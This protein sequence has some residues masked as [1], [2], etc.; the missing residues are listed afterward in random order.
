MTT[1]ELIRGAGADTPS[2]HESLDTYK[3][4]TV[5]RVTEVLCEGPIEGLATGDAR[6]IY[7][8]DVPAMG[9]DFSKNF[10]KFDYTLLT[11]SVDQ[12]GRSDF[13]FV[14]SYAPIAQ[15]VK[16]DFPVV[17]QI[18]NPEVDAVVIL[19]AFDALLTQDGQDL[20]GGKV[21]FMVEMR[22]SSSG[23]SKVSEETIDGKSRSRF[24]RAYLLNLPTAASSGPTY[25]QIRVSR[26]TPDSTE[27]N[28]INKFYL[29]GIT[30]R[31][32]TVM[33]YPYTS[34]VQFK[35]DA[36]QFPNIPTRK[37]L[38][39]LL[40]VQVPSNYNPAT[41]A[42]TGAWDGSFGA[43]QWTDNPAWC[44]Y[45][46]LTSKRYGL[47][48]FLPASQIDRW[49]FYQIARYC[50]QLVPTGRKLENGDAEMEPRFTLNC[51]I[52]T[53]D[54]ALK[55]LSD[56]VTVFRGM[57]YWSGNMFTVTQDSPASP[58]MQ[59][60]PANVADGLFTYQGSSVRNRHTVAVVAWANP[61]N[62]YKTD[63]EYVEDTDGISRYGIRKLELTAF[64][65]TSR[66]QARRVG[67]WALY[68]EL[69]ETETV[70]FSVS[71]D[72]A[73]VRPGDI[74][75]VTD[76][77]R[78][79]TP[80]A[81][82]DES[83]RM[84]GRLKA[85]TVGQL[86]LDSPV[87]LKA[88]ESYTL[89]VLMPDGTLADRTVWLAGRT[90]G[91]AGTGDTLLCS[92][93]PVAPQV[94]SLWMLSRTN[95]KPQLFRVVGVA[96][97]DTLDYEIT[98]V[99]HNPSKYAAIDLA[100]PL[101]SSSS[102]NLDNP[103]I[104][105]PVRNL[106]AV[107]TVVV[108]STGIPRARLDI[109]WQA[110]EKGYA[111]Y[112]VVQYRRQNDNWILVQRGAD[113]WATVKDIEPGVY[114]VQVI[115]VNMAG[116]HSVPATVFTTAVGKTAKPPLP[117][118]VV[119]TGG[120]QQINLA[121]TYPVGEEDIACVEIYAGTSSD[122]TQ[123]QHIVDV[124]FPQAQFANIGLALDTHIYYWIRCRDTSGNVSD[125][126]ATADA[127]TVRDPD[128]ILEHIRAQVSRS[129]LVQDLLRDI[130]LPA[131]TLLDL[132]VRVDWMNDLLRDLK[133]KTDAVIE[134]DPAD[135]RIRMKATK[136][137]DQ[138]AAAVVSEANTRI[139]GQTVV[140]EQIDQVVAANAGNAAAIEAE[141]QA[142]VDA[143]S[144]QAT[145]TEMLGARMTNA[146]AAIS[147]EQTA[148][149]TAD[150]A[151]ATQLSTLGATVSG[152][153]AAITAEQTARANADSALS[154]QIS[155]VSAVANNAQSA[156]TTETNARVTAINSEANTRSNADST[157]QTNINAVSSQVTT[158][159][160]NAAN[161][162]AAV[163]QTLQTNINT[164]SG[165]VDAMYA[166]KIQTLSN[167]RKVVSG[168]G[169]RADATGTEF[170]VVADRF[171]VVAPG[172][173]TLQPMFTIDNSS[174]TPKAVL[175][176]NLIVSGSVAANSIL[177]GEIV[178]D[179]S[180]NNS[181]GRM[182]SSNFS[183]GSAGWQIQGNGSAEF[184]NV[185]VRGT[186]DTGRIVVGTSGAVLV[187][188]SYQ[189]NPLSPV[190]RLVCNPGTFDSA[191]QIVPLSNSTL[192]GPGP[193]VET[194]RRLRGGSVSLYATVTLLVDAYVTLWGRQNGG[195]WQAIITGEGAGDGY[196]PVTLA[197]L[198]N[199]NV[200]AYDYFDFGIS[201]T[202]PSMV[203][204]PNGTL[205]QSP[206]LTVL[207]FNW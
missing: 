156:V 125:G 48:A 37:Y 193:N 169:L 35:I 6:S 55:V 157:L 105:S 2:P 196:N 11:G 134:V 171:Y 5:L 14:E 77:T 91:Q 83:D 62:T 151:L 40:K 160:T 201:S 190:A 17:H 65:C 132:S 76:P 27:A 159:Q 166:V 26:I 195:G 148:R 23:W 16:K 68:T 128:T 139:D 99:A 72:S 155:Q 142:R 24:Q 70:N 202:T 8:N 162:L 110:P 82:G 75:S 43:A 126:W 123:A 79:A 140:A 61:E 118:N 185:T 184:N 49:A 74:I 47:G 88:G 120:V 143:V 20:K 207:G 41:R 107:E 187:D 38:L 81:A 199:V 44:L 21:E 96:C 204:S 50:D 103:A 92:P 164:V 133:T 71:L 104:S 19:I 10:D 60:S 194:S 25:R 85:A 45:D 95:L 13:E 176:G 111:K 127:A 205:I 163:Q 80:T 136:V 117:A 167:G 178:A 113:M 78:L 29:E 32:G 12:R 144:A 89:S 182:R 39:K 175:A 122:Q 4:N 174:G 172:S 94:N 188:R 84:G 170:A 106:L 86:T 108:T 64:G 54:Q 146:E 179:L 154:T 7:F 51:V 177:S 147:D 67:K 135:G 101:E 56:L 42:Y 130:D 53:R 46:L 150:S 200:G 30:Y 69:Y 1:Y 131:I 119:A 137:L 97:K 28:V 9:S 186:L 165:N 15:P 22:N 73:M 93:L 112:Y 161:N 18:D 98:A 198:I 109:T 197:T 59:Y 152:N 180:M 114:E 181:S 124:P 33:R 121:W 183:S 102:S 168:F 3:S 58:V 145:S 31:T 63:Y 66:G 191:N 138:L 115:A 90:L 192:Y 116:V 149:A 129:Q 206:S 189:N 57:F 34:L 158:V 203:G 87:T 36:E 141:R 100:E 173:T 153:T 52:Q